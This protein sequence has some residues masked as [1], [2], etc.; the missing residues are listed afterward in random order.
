MRNSCCEFS[1]TSIASMRFPG[2]LTL[3]VGNVNNGLQRT[4]S[5]LANATAKLDAHT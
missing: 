3:V 1:T 2:S 4:A 5:S